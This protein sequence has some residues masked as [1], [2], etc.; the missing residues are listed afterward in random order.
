[1]QRTLPP[2]ATLIETSGDREVGCGGDG[3]GVFGL[4]YVMGL[5]GDG[6]LMA[7]LGGQHGQENPFHVLLEACVVKTYDHFYMSFL[8]NL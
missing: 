2:G 7:D 4:F 6:C 5:G 1:M 8:G 3:G